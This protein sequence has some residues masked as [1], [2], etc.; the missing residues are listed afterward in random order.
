MDETVNF[1]S[2]YLLQISCEKS[3]DHHIWQTAPNNR[4]LGRKKTCRSAKKN[5][6]KTNCK[7][8]EHESTI[9]HWS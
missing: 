5:N 1:D 8:L 4:Q 2:K 7:N 3:I 6:E 9:S